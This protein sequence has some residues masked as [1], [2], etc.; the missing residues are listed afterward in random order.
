MRVSRQWLSGWGLWA[1]VTER[2]KASLG[3]HIMLFTSDTLMLG[4]PA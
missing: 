2:E 3:E 4:V 1:P